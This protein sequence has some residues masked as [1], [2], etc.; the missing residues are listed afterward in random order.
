LLLLLSLLFLIYKISTSIQRRPFLN[1]FRNLRL[2]ESLHRA[3]KEP[4]SP[5]RP[6]SQ[7]SVAGNRSNSHWLRPHHHRIYAPIAVAFLPQNLLCLPLLLRRAASRA[8]LRLEHWPERPRRPASVQRRRVPR[9][10]EIQTP[11]AAAAGE[12]RPR[13]EKRNRHGARAPEPWLLLYEVVDSPDATDAAGAARYSRKGGRRRRRGGGASGIAGTRAHVSTVRAQSYETVAKTNWANSASSSLGWMLGTLP[14][15]FF[16]Q[17]QRHFLSLGV[18]F[19]L[20]F[21]A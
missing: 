3:W 11:V 4:P 10:V 19:S 15:F 20:W 5:L 8:L 7:F 21:S 6:R 1:N 9:A 12:P 17:V 14:N 18:F 2:P 13:P 16:V